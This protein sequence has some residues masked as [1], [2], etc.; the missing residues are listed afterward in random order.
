MPPKPHFVNSPRQV[1]TSYRPFC[2]ALFGHINA[3]IRLYDSGSYNVTSQCY[4]RQACVMLGEKH[5]I[6]ELVPNSLFPPPVSEEST[7]KRRD[8]GKVV[9]YKIRALY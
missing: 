8:R 1:K 2:P 7:R 4:L 9:I 3:P 5:I 6:N